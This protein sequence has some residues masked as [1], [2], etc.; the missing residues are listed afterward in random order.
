MLFESVGQR[1][2]HKTAGLVPQ[3]N[4]QR[5]G[6]EDETAVDD[7]RSVLHAM[8]SR[9]AERPSAAMPDDGGPM[10]DLVDDL[11]A[12][13]AAAREAG[14]W[15]TADAIRDALAKAGIDVRDEAA[16][17]SLVPGP[18]PRS[19]AASSSR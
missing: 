9:L 7:A 10:G 11:A 18:R 16:A 14:Q 6:G 1:L 12:I 5:A 17:S 3:A 4:S 2:V 19:R 8:I 15:V 13:R